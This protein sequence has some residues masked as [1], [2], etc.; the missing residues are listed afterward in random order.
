MHCFVGGG[1]AA[2]FYFAIS[3]NGAMFDKDVASF[4]VSRK[5][6]WRESWHGLHIVQVSSGGILPRCPSYPCA[7]VVV[8]QPVHTLL[9]W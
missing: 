4:V 9:S 2:H 7:I 5:R 1:D 6:K 3:A 8:P